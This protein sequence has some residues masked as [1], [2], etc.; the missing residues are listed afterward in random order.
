MEFL[1]GYA[2]LLW[3]LFLSKFVWFFFCRP[4]RLAGQLPFRQLASFCTYLVGNVGPL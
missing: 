3:M 4:I 1:L 2:G